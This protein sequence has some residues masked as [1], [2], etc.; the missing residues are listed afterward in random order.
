MFIEIFAGK[1]E[2]TQAFLDSGITSLA[3]VDIEGEGALHLDLLKKLK[4]DAA[5]VEATV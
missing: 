1:G 5:N 4:F 2:L 3:R